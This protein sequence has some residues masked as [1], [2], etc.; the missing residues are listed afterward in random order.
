V[1]NDE[2]NFELQEKK[3]RI[4][5]ERARSQ[6]CLE[7]LRFLE[8][9]RTSQTIAVSKIQFGELTHGAEGSKVACVVNRKCNLNFK[10]RKQESGRK[11]PGTQCALRH[12]DSWKV[13]APVK[14]IC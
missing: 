11:V 5:Q 8:A 4:G 14:F 3:A 7:A 1:L 2:C 6:V 9:S 12:L 10:E 13:H